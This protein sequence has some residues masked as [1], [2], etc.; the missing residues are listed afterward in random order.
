MLSK[1]ELKEMI[2][3]F[4]LLI[5]KDL[6]EVNSIL[7]IQNK[8]KAQ[9]YK[10]LRTGIDLKGIRPLVEETLKYI[11]EELDD[12]T[13]DMYDLEIAVDQ[14][15]Q[16][17]DRREVIHSDEIL[18]EITIE[19]REDNRITENT[20][21]RD[22]KF[23]VVQIYS[24]KNDKSLYLFMKY[25]HPSKKYKKSVRYLLS[26]SGELKP[27]NNEIIVLSSVVDA[28]L[29][30]DVYYVFN[31]NDFNSFFSYKDV[32]TRIIADNRDTIRN[33]G[34]LQESEQFL[35]DCEKDGRY[36][37]RLTKAIL[38]KSFE[39]VA[40]REKEIPRVV[41]SFNLSLEI[42]EKG[43]IVYR[44]KEDIPE[45]LNLLLRHYVID[46]LTTN[47]MIAAAIQEYQIGGTER[48]QN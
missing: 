15:V 46:A 44:G 6:V 7:M 47:K 40:K 13:L 35:T 1:E 33:S 28:M 22:I 45:L 39:E 25:I 29:F 42:S 23:T 26:G 31:R 3:D 38:A 19:D 10:G 16:M 24:I 2:F 5:E 27:F 18:G 37:P 41:E 43:K 4:K 17:V 8:K 36:L 30:D 34:L 12:R 11:S 20:D 9:Q 48:S 21:L 32:F 14:S